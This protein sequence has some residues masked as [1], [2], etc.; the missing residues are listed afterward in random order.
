M[1][2]YRGSLLRVDLTRGL[3]RVEPLR[4]DWAELYVGG[5]GLL[6]RYLFDELEPGLDP[7][8]PANR[9][10]LFTGPFA[11]TAVP[12]CSRLVVGCLSPATGTYLD[13]YVGGSFAPELKYAGFDAVIVEGRSPT[14]V[15]LVI[16]DGVATLR[17]ADA[18][19]GMTTSAIEAALKHDAD[20]AAKVLSIG[21]AGETS[22][23]PPASPRTSTTR[24]GAAALVQSWAARTSRR[25]P[26]AAPAL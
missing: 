21:P 16:T 2:F 25:S 9:L 22:C 4:M 23:P 20:D 13:S 1:D 7:L 8:G 12:T 14:P 6:L 15:V 18:Y 5:K 24:P 11:G 10:M 26:C 19:M 17:P 3:C